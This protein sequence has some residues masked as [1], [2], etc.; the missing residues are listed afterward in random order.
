MSEVFLDALSPVE[1]QVG[2][3]VVGLR[4][5]LGYEDKFVSV[6][7]KRYEHS[8]SSHPPARVVF[9]IDGRFSS[10]RSKVALNDDVRMTNSHANFRVLADGRQVG[11]EPYVGSGEPPRCLVADISGARSLELTVRSSRWEHSHAVWLDPVLSAEPAQRERVLTDCLNRVAIN[12]PVT[13]PRAER[14]I[15]TVVSPGFDKLLDDMLGS[16]SARGN[17]PDALVVVFAVDADDACRRVIKK[18]AATEIVCA[19][20]ARVNPTV[21][22]VLYGAPRVIDAEQFLCLDADMLVLGDLDPVFRAMDACPEG[23]ILA[24]REGNS[25]EP[26]TLDWAIQNIYRGRSADFSRILGSLNG[27]MQ[28]PMVVNDGLFAGGCTALLELEGLI[29]GWTKA[30][31][32]V[33]ERP[34]V[35]WRN[36][37]VFNLALAKLNCGVELDPTYNLH[38]QA[39]DVEMC[40]TNG[41]VEAFWRGREAKVLH[42]CGWGR[43]K[44][45]EWRG[46]FAR[47]AELK[48]QQA[49]EV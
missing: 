42:F 45:P 26:T 17:C 49:V 14:C 38:L 11:I 33:D 16:L 24:C 27:E 15:A 46:I 22:A 2:Y 39:Q 1:A 30:S 4:G 36:Q 7:A 5:S 28:Y 48:G 32:W 44:Y 47:A 37:F 6:G 12:V 40:R 29:R 20:R 43:N 35:W 34:D 13:L 31:A 9:Q 23:S 18:Y 8:L 21:K 41:R 25:R 10:F 19:R 3:G